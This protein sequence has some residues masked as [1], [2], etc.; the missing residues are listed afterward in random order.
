MDALVKTRPGVD[1]RL[2]D[3]PTPEPQRNE[4]RIRILKTAICGT[5]VHIYE[6]DDWARRTLP[7][8]LVIGHEFVGV[9]EKLGEGV[10]G[11]EVGEIVTG[12]GHIV[13]GHC[14]NC[15]AGRSHLCMNT[16]SVGTTRAGAFAEYLVLPAVNVWP[17]DPRIPLEVLAVFDPLGNAVHAALSYDLTGEDVL[18]TGA[19]PLGC[20]AAA[21]ARHVGARYVVITDVNPWRLEL[22]RTMGVDLAVEAS[23]ESIRDAMRKLGMKEGFDVG[24][25]MS[26]DPRALRDMLE[27]MYHGG[28]IA[29]LGLLE[30]E[31][32]I[33]WEKVIFGSL[34]LKGIYGREMFETWYKMTAFIQSG[35]DITPVITHRFPCAEFEVAFETMR[36]G[37]SG[38]VILEWAEV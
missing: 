30:G 26:G 22:A 37:R 19:G 28:R 10:Q 9:I 29:L 25:E 27:V 21:I 16:V 20:M 4:V 31:S 1:L 7:L 23:P 36:S 18:I 15:L 2:L 13:C 11:L 33:D 5:D 3:V 14:R 12:E 34:T 32:A 24:L 38:K 35:L 6:W 8:P 17:A